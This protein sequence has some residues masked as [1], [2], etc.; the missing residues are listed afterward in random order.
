MFEFLPY[1]ASGL[2]VCVAEHACSAVRLRLQYDRA[3]FPKST[4]I[5]KELATLCFRPEPIVIMHHGHRTARRWIP[6][7][8]AGGV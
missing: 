2:A 6:S 1:V 4:H 5:V 7:A 3:R 8:P